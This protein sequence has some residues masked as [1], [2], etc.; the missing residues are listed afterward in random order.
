[1]STEW[2]EEVNYKFNLIM[3]ALSKKICSNKNLNKHFK[4]QVFGADIAPDE[5]LNATLMEI[6]KG[7]DLD[8]K[9]DKDGE[10]KKNMVN[11]LFKIA[12]NNGDIDDTNFIKIY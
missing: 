6:N 9:D 3:R 1:M 2:N 8:Y 12:E 7:P 11:D 4:F 10:L 5:N